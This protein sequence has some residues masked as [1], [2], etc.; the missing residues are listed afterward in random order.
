MRTPAPAGLRAGSPIGA[1]NPRAP[2]MERDCRAK[3]GAARKDFYG[4]R[5]ILTLQLFQQIP[6]V[7]G[8]W[9]VSQRF[10]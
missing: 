5:L 4:R 7:L 8:I 10:V 6:R 9:L 1:P 2:D 3:A